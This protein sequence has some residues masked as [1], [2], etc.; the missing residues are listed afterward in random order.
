M[1]SLADKA[2]QLAHD[3]WAG[4]VLRGMTC[5]RV[6]RYEEG[7]AHLEQAETLRVQRNRLGTSID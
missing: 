1:L 2:A 7:L 4:E 3:A 6:E 5:Y